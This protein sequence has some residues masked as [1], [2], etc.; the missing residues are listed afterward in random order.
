MS[1]KSEVILEKDYLCLYC[2][3]HSTVEEV[4]KVFVKVVDVA[5]EHKKSRVLVD[6]NK[7]TGTFSIFERYE[8]S[9]L[10]AR[11]VIQRA[12]GKKLKIA[13][14]GQEPLIDPQRLGETV[15][16]N[17]GVNLKVT[18]DLNEAKRWLLQ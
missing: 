6:A 18:T 5:L 3:G 15:A 10:L 1:I 2:T 9:E 7:V 4:K 16:K 14:C 12:I 17:R 11:E 13:I 8:V